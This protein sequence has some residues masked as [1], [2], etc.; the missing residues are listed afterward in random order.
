MSALTVKWADPDLQVKKK[1]ALEDSNAENRMVRGA[2]AEAA[3]A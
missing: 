1:K 3:D 2:C